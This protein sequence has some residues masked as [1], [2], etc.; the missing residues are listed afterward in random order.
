MPHQ[1]M[2]EH[3]PR[4]GMAEILT[5]IW[6]TQKREILELIKQCQQS[7][8]PEAKEG[9]SRPTRIGKDKEQPGPEPRLAPEVRNIK[10]A[11]NHVT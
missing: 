6:G 8:Q 9:G 3:K 1:E 5:H 11:F 4:E 7:G 10:E 2:G